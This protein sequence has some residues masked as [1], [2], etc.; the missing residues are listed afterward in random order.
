MRPARARFWIAVV[1]LTHARA[2][3]QH[4]DWTQQVW[5]GPRQDDP[6]LAYRSAGAPAL[7]LAPGNELVVAIKGGLPSSRQPT[8]DPL[9]QATALPAGPAAPRARWTLPDNALSSVARSW[10]VP[11]A[12]VLD[13]SGGTIIGGA[14]SQL[15]GDSPCCGFDFA[16]MAVTSDGRPRWTQRQGAAGTV[17]T[18]S[19]VVVDANGTVFAAGFV[20]RDAVP[21][22]TVAAYAADGTP[23]WVHQLTDLP[24]SAARALTLDRD[25]I[26]LVI[27]QTRGGAHERF[28][29]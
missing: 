1:L 18:V 26:D 3:A 10:G 22:L 16:V 17:G 9:W 12:I 28:A 13:P 2:G 7:V 21:A 5:V 14:A 6:R 11:A 4:L 20:A 25:G 29:K 23:G 27:G 15:D 19:A 24:R 8:F